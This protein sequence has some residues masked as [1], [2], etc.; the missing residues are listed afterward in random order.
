MVKAAGFDLVI[1]E[2]PGIGQGDID[3]SIARGSGIFVATLLTAGRHPYGR[4]A[5]RVQG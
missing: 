5:R 1:V 2:T 4:T 3:P